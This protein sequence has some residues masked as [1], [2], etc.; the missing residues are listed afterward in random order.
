MVKVPKEDLSPWF[1]V[2][3]RFA[4]SLKL[5]GLIYVESPFVVAAWEIDETGGDFTDGKILPFWR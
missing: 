3:S 1:L 2:K 5:S 4:A